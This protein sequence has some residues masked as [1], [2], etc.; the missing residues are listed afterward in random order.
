M[1]PVGTEVWVR[2]IGISMSADARGE[3]FNEDIEGKVVIVRESQNTMV[4]LVYNKGRFLFHH[5]Q[6]RIKI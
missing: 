2:G 1:Y 5:S 3:I 4:V 6:I